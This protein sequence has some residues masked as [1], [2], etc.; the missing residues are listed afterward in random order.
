MR[1][2]VFD[3]KNNK[4]YLNLVVSTRQNLARQIGSR[5]FYLGNTRYS[6]N[7]V[8]AEIENDNTA[9]GA[10]IGG[11]LGLLGGPI[12]VAV[13]LALGG[14]LGNSTNDDETLKVKRFNTSR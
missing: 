5:Y 6:V 11:A 4:V 14:I 8:F 3:R 10:L 7:D 1:L 13:G 12:G 9:P 2:Y